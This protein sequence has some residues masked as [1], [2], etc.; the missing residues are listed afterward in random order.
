MSAIQSNHSEKERAFLVGAE[1]RGTRPLL[2]LE[3]SLLEL[4]LLADTAGMQVVGQ[5]SQRLQHID[6]S[7]FIGSGKVEEIREAVEALNAEVIIFDDE[8]SPR[9]QKQLE[10]GAADLAGLPH[11]AP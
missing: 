5:A 10:T 4:D 2:K 6:P 8:L 11:C 9:H 3:D 1:V 7:T